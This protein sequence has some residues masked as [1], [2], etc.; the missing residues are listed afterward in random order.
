M[1]LVF[2]PV[3]TTILATTIWKLLHQLMTYEH[4]TGFFSGAMF[5]YICYD[6]MH[7]YLH[8]AVPFSEYFKGLKSYHV[9]HHYKD[10]H[11]GYGITSKFWDYVFG[12]YPKLA[13]QASGKPLL[14]VKEE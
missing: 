6:M 9:D 8:H 2:P 7:Y 4:L 5:G 3:L 13:V 14:F 10:V 1:R 11:S 12:T